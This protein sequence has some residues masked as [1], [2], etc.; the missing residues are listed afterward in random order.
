MPTPLGRIVQTSSFFDVNHKHDLI[1]GC[2]MTRI[3]HLV[4]QT[5]IKYY[6]RRQA[7]VVTATYSLELITG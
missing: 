7:T 1:M 6:C 4:N 2:S 5:P 3:L